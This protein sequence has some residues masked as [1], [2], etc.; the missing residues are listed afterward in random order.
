M[1]PAVKQRYL[2]D[3]VILIDHLNGDLRATKWL[4]ALG[5]DEAFI[6]PITRAEVLAGAT[7]PER[8]DILAMLDDYACLSITAAT[9]DSAANL[10]QQYRWKLPDAFQAALATEHNLIFATRNTKDFVEAKHPFVKIPY[11]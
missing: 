6:S 11:E 4:A 2:V 9:A 8:P 7:E 5:D 1:G 10:R 3:S